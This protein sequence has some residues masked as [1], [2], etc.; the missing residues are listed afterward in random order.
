[1]HE[2]PLE[3]WSIIGR[4]LLHYRIIENLGGGMVEACRL[5]ETTRCHHAAI[6]LLRGHFGQMLPAL[7][8]S[9]PASF[10]RLATSAWRSQAGWGVKN[11][12]PIAAF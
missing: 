9:A 12:L 3:A 1:M 4:T 5:E 6:K 11:R 8:P 7:P 10:M 2:L